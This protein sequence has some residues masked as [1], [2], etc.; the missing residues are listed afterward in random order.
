VAPAGTAVPV[1]DEDEN[2]EPIVVGSRILATERV[3]IG[4]IRRQCTNEY[5]IVPIRRKV[6]ELLGI[7]GQR[8]PTSPVAEQWISISLDEAVRIK[9][10]FE[11][12]QINRWPLI[13]RGMTRLDCLNWLERNGYP[14]PPK[15]ACI[16]CPFHTDVHW[17]HMRDHDPDA[18]ADAVSVD[19][20]IRIGFRGIR[21]EVYLH[22]SAVPLD[23]ADLSTAADRG[24]LDLWLNECEGVSGV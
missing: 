7:A 13:E 2:G 10:S 11:H 3:E 5:K 18:W 8:S 12:W 6:R 16:G 22:R 21:G 17:R 24:Q 9:P 4:M 23:Q 15:S 14:R 20:T 19:R 1:C